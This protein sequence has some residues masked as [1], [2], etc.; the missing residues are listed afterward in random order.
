MVQH[1]AFDERS[2]QVG[3]VCLLNIKVRKGAAGSVG[4]R[5]RTIYSHL[6]EGYDIYKHFDRLLSKFMSI[7]LL[8]CMPVKI[9]ALHLLVGSATGVMSLVLPS[10]KQVMG[11][12]CRLRMVVH[13]GLDCRMLE[14]LSVYGITRKN[15]NE[16]LSGDV[17]HADFVAWLECWRRNKMSRRD[18]TTSTAPLEESEHS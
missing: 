6:L 1:L 8:H 2:T 10:M 4:W 15:L 3:C 16:N 14:T 9:K 12:E 7:I 17:K 5:F 11:K 18:S 13:S